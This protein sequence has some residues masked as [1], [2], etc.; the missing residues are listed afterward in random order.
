LF[1]F[2]NAYTMWQESNNKLQ[3]T[4]VF[5]NFTRAFTFMTACAF[6][7]EKLNH[8]PDWRNVY[9]R[10][11]VH[12]STHDAGNVVTEKDRTLA[13]IMDAIYDSMK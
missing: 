13:R 8:H 11:E 7:A 10:V 5:E 12:L 6:E 1:I 9:N 3:K 4:F 2:E